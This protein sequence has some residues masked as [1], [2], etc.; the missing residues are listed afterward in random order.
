[1]A[2][3]MTLAKIQA[4]GVLDSDEIL[5]IDIPGQKIVLGDNSTNDGY[6][7]TANPLPVG[8]A[9]GSLT[10]DGTVIAT[11]DSI[12]VRDST[13]VIMNGSTELTPKFAVISL[14]ATGTLVDGV[15]NKKIR[16]LALAMTLD[17]VTGDETYTFNSAAGGTPKTGVLGDTSGA[18][19]TIPFVLGY[20][21]LGWFETDAAALLELEIAGTTPNAQGM[22]TYVE[23]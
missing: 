22:L 4:G 13:D 23:V 17:I 12:G 3:G 15:T 20:N 21:P 7:S 1:M 14:T 6:V 2:D 16:V 19:V 8:D 11:G 10:V 5:G 18:S 9:G